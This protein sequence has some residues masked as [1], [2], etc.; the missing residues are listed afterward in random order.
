V[1]KELIIKTNSDLLAVLFFFQTSAIGMNSRMPG[2][3]PGKDYMRSAVQ[4]VTLA[5]VFYQLLRSVFVTIIPSIIH[6]YLLTYLLTYSM[7]QSPS[8][9][10]DRFAASQEIPRVLWNPKV[11]YRIHKCPPPVPILSQLD[12]VHTPTPS[13]FLNIRLNILRPSTTGTAKWSLSL[14]FPHSNPVHASSLSYTCYM[15]L[16]SHSSRFNH[17]NYIG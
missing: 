15:S 1:G 14:R 11:H 16:P 3:C 5:L 6:A 12:P 13:H 2:L 7:E 8:R 4:E 10:A 9:E 17:P